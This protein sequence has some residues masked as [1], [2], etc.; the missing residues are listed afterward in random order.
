[1]CVFIYYIYYNIYDGVYNKII[2][3]E[4]CMLLFKAGLV[5]EADVTATLKHTGTYN[6]LDDIL[7]L[8]YI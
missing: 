5:A 6:G 4:Y 1:M 2:S 3:I 8:N 7:S